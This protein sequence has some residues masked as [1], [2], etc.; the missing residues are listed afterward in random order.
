[1]S[2]TSQAVAQL[3][4]E[5]DRPHTSEGD[6]DAQRRLCRGMPPAGS[7]RIRDHVAARTRFFD[8]QVLD[9][10][11]G[12]VC[13]VVICGAGYDDRAQRFRSAGVRI[14]ELDQRITQGDKSR[15]LK[16]LGVDTSNLAL[17][18]ADFRTDDVATVL[19]RCGHDAAQPSLFVCEGLLVYLDQAACVRLLAGL[20]SRAAPGSLLAASLATHPAGVDSDRLA[21]VANA[22]RRR[23]E[24]EPWRTI[25]PRDAHLD[26]LRRSGWHVEHSTNVPSLHPQVNPDGS[27]LVVASP[28]PPP[29]EPGGDAT[30]R[31]R[32]ERPRRLQLPWG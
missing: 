20:S 1:M 23:G 21:A 24:S 6:P 7:S 30:D 26:L 13:Q 17:A 3:R 31:P 12:G 16:A 9:A 8:Q 5:L 22:R 11:A 18:P 28:V 10:I 29:R 14:F 19:R 25:L 27:L 2:R 4:A 32:R 15:R